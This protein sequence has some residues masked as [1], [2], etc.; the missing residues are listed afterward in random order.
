MAQASE[1]IGV[2]LFDSLQNT[3]I[4]VAEI[5]GNHLLALDEAAL[6][7]CAE[8]QGFCIAFDFTDLDFQLYCHPGSWGLRLSRG[9]PARDVDAS[10][11]G[12]LMS[13]VDLATDDDKLS[14]SM[15]ERVSFHGNIAIAQK[16]QA[17]LAGLDIDW[18]EM[19][20]RHCGDVLA[21]QLHQRARKFS[22]WLRYGADSL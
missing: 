6:R 18:E 1:R 2:T 9:V 12:R 13:L 14:T 7:G 5:G 3:L 19:L 4:A 22:D 16:M 11:S 17:I 10:I 8:L 15:R 21:F 20:A